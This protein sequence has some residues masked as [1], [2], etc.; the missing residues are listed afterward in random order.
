MLAD[1][2]VVVSEL[3]VVVFVLALSLAHQCCTWRFLGRT[4]I[5]STISTLYA[6]RLPLMFRSVTKTARATKECR[7]GERTVIDTHH[8]SRRQCCRLGTCSSCFGTCSLSRSPMLHMAVSWSHT[9][10][11]YNQHNHLYALRLPLMFR[12]ITK[13]TRAT[14]KRGSGEPTVRDTH[15]AG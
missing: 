15:P 9:Y 7:S 12:S 3:A 10:I 5:S 2:S 8:A 13:T 14:T 4:P 6:F 11:Q 1:G